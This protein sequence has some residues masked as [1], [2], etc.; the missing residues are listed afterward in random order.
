MSQIH[1]TIED[2]KGYKKLLSIYDNETIEKGKLKIGHEVSMEWIFNAEILENNKTFR[3]YEI[4]N[5]ETIIAIGRYE[6]GGGG[7]LG[8]STIDVSKNKTTNLGFDKNG[9]A[10]RYVIRG[11]NIY[12]KCKDKNK[13][14]QAYNDSIYVQIGYVKNWNLLEN[15]DKIRCPIC[16][17]RVKPLNFGFWDC[18]YEIEYEKDEDDEYKSGSVKGESGIGEFKIFE[19]YASGRATFT[20]LIFN[21]TSNN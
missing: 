2:A 7:M 11:L 5:G 4:K 15:I 9:P 8:V 1:I 21:I 17:E 3:D 16:N 12:S 20:K 6:A 13:K 19:E 18:K 14:C 10:Y